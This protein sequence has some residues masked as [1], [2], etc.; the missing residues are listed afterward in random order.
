MIEINELKIFL[1]VSRQGS[2]SRA[3]A[4]LNYVQSNVTA[5]IKQLEERLGTSLFHRKSKGVCLTASGYLLLDYAE[6]IIRLTREA[7]EALSDQHRP[8]GPLAIGSMETTA[9]VR[10]PALL[11]DFH[12]SYPDVEL[13][14]ITGPSETSLRRLLNFQL[15]GALVAGEVSHDALIAER[16]FEEELVIVAPP[17]SNPLEKANLKILVFRPGCSYRAQLETWLR[18]TGRQAYRIIEFGSIEGI[19]GCVAAGMGISLLPRSVVDQPQHLRNCS[20]HSVPAEFS[21][22]TTWFVRRRN[23]KSSRALQAFQD[24]L[25]SAA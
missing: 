13:S 11:A 16:V 4:E 14:L 17:E 9:A 23:E 12:L 10:L 6:R 19:I 20:L 2:I 5:R 25:S 3:A 8:H 18:K 7:E 15:D 22:M 21:K 1:S 24:K